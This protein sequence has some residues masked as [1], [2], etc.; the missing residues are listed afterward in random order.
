[1]TIE[2]AKLKV[3]HPNPKLASQ[4]AVGRAL[5]KILADA[6]AH[7]WSMSKTNNAMEEVLSNL[8]LTYTDSYAS[9]PS[10]MAPGT[11]SGP[12]VDGDKLTQ[13][14]VAACLRGTIDPAELRTVARAARL[15]AVAPTMK[16]Y[17]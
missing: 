10:E 4:E 15:T 12:V 7:G 13:V 6:N 1:M 2:P 5:R 17:G 16:G 3:S 9:D 8:R 14:I 11:N